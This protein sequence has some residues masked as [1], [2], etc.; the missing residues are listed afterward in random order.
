MPEVLP[1]AHSV[2]APAVGRNLV[3]MWACGS[4]RGG[5]RFIPQN[6][7]RPNSTMYSLG[8]QG[9]HNS[10]QLSHNLCRARKL[11]HTA[12]ERLEFAVYHA[13]LTGVQT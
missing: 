9:L 12:S 1:Y 2:L 11:R 4:V 7:N 13:H 3:K 10:V 6:S 5:C 8:K